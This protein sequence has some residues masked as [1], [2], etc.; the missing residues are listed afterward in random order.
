MN[1]FDIRVQYTDTGNVTSPR[2]C[3]WVEVINE[4]ISI[5]IDGQFETDLLIDIKTTE[6]SYSITGEKLEAM[7]AEVFPYSQDDGED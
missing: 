5:T 7:L 2:N 6:R 4:F 1:P 3:K